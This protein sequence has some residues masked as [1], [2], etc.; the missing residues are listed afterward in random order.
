MPVNWFTVV[1][2]IINFLILVWLLKRFLY[3]PILHALDEREKGIAHRLAEAEAKQATAERERAEFDRRN[4]EFDRDRAALLKNAV[5]EAK[6]QRQKL[7]DEAR[8]AADSLTA[9][10]QEELRM[11]QQRLKEEIRCWIHKE[12]FAIARK[13]L[14][15]L[16]DESLEDRMCELFI[17]RLQA[18]PDLAVDQI[19]GALTSFDGPVHVRS[20]FD[21]TSARQDE[22]AIEIKKTF[23]KDVSVHF[24]TAPEIV[25]GIEL[26]VDGRKIA[27]SVADYLTSLE[28]NVAQILNGDACAIIEPD[29]SLQ[30][31]ISSTKGNCES[32]A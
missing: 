30:Q 19:A 32:L 4:E 26:I 7:L 11:E 29:H 5:E 28:R 17:Q 27:W 21:L 12:V 3:Q 25:S 9:K 23:D 13:T 6:E 1:A 16:A 15:D 2:Q 31:Q 20:A 22:I 10:R 14:K 8:N 24:D 18:L